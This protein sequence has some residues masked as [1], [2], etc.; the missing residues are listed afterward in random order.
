LPSRG[1]LMIDPDDR[2]EMGHSIHQGDGAK[3]QMTVA[4]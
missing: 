2:M 3:G 1:S 4:S